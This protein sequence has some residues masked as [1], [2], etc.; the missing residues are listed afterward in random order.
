MQSAAP[1][2][3]D[4]VVSFPYAFPQPGKYHVWV[5]VKHSGRVLTGAF[6]IDVAPS[7]T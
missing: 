6:A 1:L 3:T 4:G 2:P 5:Q 7:V